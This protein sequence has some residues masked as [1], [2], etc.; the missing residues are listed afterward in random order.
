VSLGILRA[1]YCPDLREL[2]AAAQR[3]AT[4]TGYEIMVRAM[5]EHDF[6]LSAQL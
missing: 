1:P 3:I 2:G 6:I 4:I 5:S